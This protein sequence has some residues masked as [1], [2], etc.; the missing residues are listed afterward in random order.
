MAKKPQDHKTKKPKPQEVS[1]V[2]AAGVTL[3]IDPEVF[4]DVELLGDVADLQDGNGLKLVH[5]LR[6]ICGNQY[7]TVLDALR[8]ET[9]GRVPVGAVEVFMVDLF[10]ALNPNS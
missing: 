10:G 5:V 7:K 3:Q 1:T 2:T 6:R 8:D 9:T 4:D